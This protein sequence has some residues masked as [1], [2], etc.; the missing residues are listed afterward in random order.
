MPGT[1][2]LFDELAGPPLRQVIGGLLAAA[3]SA[4]VAIAHVRLAA[5]DLD[6]GELRRVRCRLLMGQL[7]VAALAELRP[8]AE[9][10]L[11]LRTIARFLDSGRREVRSAGLLRWRPDFSI[12]VLPPPHQ[13][14]ALVGALYFA[15]A[16]VAGG[17]ALTC[18]VRG[19]AAVARLRRR[20]DDLWVRARDV[21]DVVRAELAARGAPSTRP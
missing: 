17:P 6:A 3:V 4:D 11:H 14:V 7:D 15:D 1:V 21:G 18:V 5:I 13:P 12:F 9:A 19:P 2:L 10:A 8:R 20:F 16:A